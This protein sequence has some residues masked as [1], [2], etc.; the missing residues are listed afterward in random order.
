VMLC[1]E[2]IVL[3]QIKL[4]KSCSDF[5]PE[6]KECKHPRSNEDQEQNHSDDQQTQSTI[7]LSRLGDRDS[8]E[9]DK[10]PEE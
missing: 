6:P 2:P 9:R 7:L 4:E 5:S 10:H 1:H 8:H 3:F